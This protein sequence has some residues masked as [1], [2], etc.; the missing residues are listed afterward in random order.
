MHLNFI[1]Q[2][3]FV[4]FSPSYTCFSISIHIPMTLTST[5]G[6]ICEHIIPATPFSRSH[7]RS[8]L[9]DVP[10]TSL[11]ENSSP[12]PTIRQSGPMP[13]AP[14]SARHPSVTK[15]E[16][17]SPSLRWTLRN[18]IYVRYLIGQFRLRRRNALTTEVRKILDLIFKHCVHCCFFKQAYSCLWRYTIVEEG[19][20]DFYSTLLPLIYC[21]IYKAYVCSPEASR[22]NPRPHCGRNRFVSN[23]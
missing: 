21:H 11:Q 10:V 5:N 22:N 8:K 4:D 1:P 15:H 17:Q 13:S 7:L 12:P 23:Q 6:R 19:R 2:I 18:W 14:T 9:A 16:C 20:Q 3:Y